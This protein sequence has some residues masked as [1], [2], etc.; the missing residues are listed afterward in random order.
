M[1]TLVYQSVYRRVARQNPL[2]KCGFVLVKYRAGER[3]E[4]RVTVERKCDKMKV[5]TNFAQ[6]EKVY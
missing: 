3:L 2:R 5:C 1:L 6:E 4:T